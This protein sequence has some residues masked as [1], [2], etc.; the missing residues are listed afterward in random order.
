MIRTE[1]SQAVRLAATAG[2]TPA[3]GQTIGN[4]GKSAVMLLPLLRFGKV[5]LLIGVPVFVVHA[6]RQVWD[7]VLGRLDDRR[8]DFQTAISAQIALLGNRV[9]AE[10]EREVRQRLTDLHTWQEHSVRATA[11]Q[12]VDERVGLF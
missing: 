9:G 11:N 1:L 2:Q 10:F 7:Y 5:G 8:G 3:I 6:G 12:M 4:I